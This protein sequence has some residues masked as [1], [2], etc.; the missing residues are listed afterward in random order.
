MLLKHGE[1]AWSSTERKNGIEDQVRYGLQET[2]LNLD[3]KSEVQ[4]G[5]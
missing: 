4:N 2:D 5:F 3:D 1:N